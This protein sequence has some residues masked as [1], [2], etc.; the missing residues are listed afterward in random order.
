MIHTYCSHFRIGSV[1]EFAAVLLAREDFVEQY[2]LS[3][4]V[5]LLCRALGQSIRF[6]TRTCNIIKHS[7]TSGFYRFPNA[8]ESVFFL[9]NLHIGDWL[10]MDMH[11]VVC[12]F[13]S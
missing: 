13:F 11:H 1:L 10:S 3:F 2:M 5:R 6:P 12:F 8:V 4:L 9:I 7:V